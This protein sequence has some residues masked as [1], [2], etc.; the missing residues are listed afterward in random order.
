M[1]LNI[2]QCMEAVKTFVEGASGLS[3]VTIGEPESYPRRA[4]AW[5]DLGSVSSPDKLVGVTVE[6]TVE[7]PVWIAHRVKGDEGAALRD[8]A[9]AVT[10]MLQAF[11]PPA[12]RSLGVGDSAQID[13]SA[14]TDQDWRQVGGQEV[15]LFPVYFRIKQSQS[16]GV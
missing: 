7:V 1:T 13:A 15:R 3:S 14:A 9:N 16:Y 11:G 2:W 12:N 6:Y 10:A 5:V 8:T 4:I